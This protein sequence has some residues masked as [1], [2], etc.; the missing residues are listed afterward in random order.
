MKYSLFG[1]VDSD[2]KT[3]LIWQELS[4]IWKNPDFAS[5]INFPIRGTFKKD[6]FKN[7]YL[8]GFF[9]SNSSC[10]PS[11]TMRGWTKFCQTWAKG[12][13]GT[14]HWCEP[15]S[16]SMEH[17]CGFD[18]NSLSKLRPGISCQMKE[19][20][21]RPYW[22]IIEIG[23]DI[24]TLSTRSNSKKSKTSCGKSEFS[25]KYFRFKSDTKDSKWS[26]EL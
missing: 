18:R 7:L 17:R 16:M 25:S 8:H 5:T 20:K 3:R 4:Q 23:T 15:S 14:G 2:I 11:C 6:S 26:N 12:C 9:D 1:T 13:E 22:S 19:S 10:E 24:L 21:A